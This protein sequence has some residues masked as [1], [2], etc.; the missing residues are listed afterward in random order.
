MNTNGDSTTQVPPV[1]PPLSPASSS[2]SSTNTDT[3]TQTQEQSG[4]TGTNNGSVNTTQ[5]QDAG[6]LALIATYDQRIR[7]LQSSYDKVINE[8]NQTITNLTNLQEEY[9]RLKAQMDTSIHSSATTAQQ[10]L[11]HNRTLEQ[12]ID[13]IK[14]QLNRANAL[15]ENP[16]LAPYARFVPASIDPE[17]VKQE[18]E[19]LKQIRQQDLDRLRGNQSSQGY[20]QQQQSS[21]L[22]N[23]S[24][25][26]LY[27]GRTNMAPGTQNQN[28][29]T[30]EVPGSTPAQMNPMAS[31]VNP[32]DEI[33]R[34]LTE[35]RASG[36][37]GKFQAALERAKE[38]APTAVNMQMGR[39][40]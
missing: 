31:V 16:D 9:S 18:V 27:Q 1:T 38:L 19:Q 34:I 3:N 29:Q 35:A 20:S 26:N 36:D 13:D 5:Q 28:Q 17:K 6:Y 30:Q 24:V 23:Q 14:G 2:S 37:P 39:S 11:D 32:T 7:G 15:L 33:N 40:S 21:Q 4:S 8:R 10:A 22:G 25:L 12:Q